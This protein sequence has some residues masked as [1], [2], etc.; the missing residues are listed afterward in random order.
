[1]IVPSLDEFRK[2]A[3]DNALVPYIKKSSRT[4]KRRSRPI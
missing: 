2:L 1:M 3:H 4:W